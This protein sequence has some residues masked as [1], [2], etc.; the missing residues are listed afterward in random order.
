MPPDVTS[1][2]TEHCVLDSTCVT[3]NPLLLTGKAV[4][5]LHHA[6][7]RTKEFRQVSTHTWTLVPDGGSFI[8]AV[9]VY[10][11]YW[12]VLRV[13][14]G[15]GG[16]LKPG[17][18]LLISHTIRNTRKETKLPYVTQR[19]VVTVNIWHKLLQLACEHLYTKKQERK[20]RKWRNVQISWHSVLQCNSWSNQYSDRKLL[21]CRKQM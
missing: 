2:R 13:L 14:P 8:S 6:L 19:R 1:R 11:I 9:P 15:R 21:T 4:P 5:H 18:P 16:R 3:W 20:I 10:F 7:A 12:R 17:R